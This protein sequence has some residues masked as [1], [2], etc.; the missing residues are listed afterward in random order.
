[1]YQTICI[2]LLC[3]LSGLVGY[4]VLFHKPAVEVLTVVPESTVPAKPTL[5]QRV[6]NRYPV[7]TQFYYL[8]VRMIVVYSYDST[9]GD[10]GWGGELGVQYADKM[11]IIHKHVFQPGHEPILLDIQPNAGQP[12]A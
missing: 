8:G 10:Y 7:G 11:G 12:A 4:H 6:L 1:M 3:V 2:V 9:T 5:W